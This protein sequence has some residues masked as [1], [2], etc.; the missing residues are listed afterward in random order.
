MT[1]SK[2]PTHIIGSTDSLRICGTKSQPWTIE[3]PFG[4]KLHINALSFTMTRSDHSTQ[5][6]YKY[7]VIV[8]RI[9][10]RNASICGG[11]SPREKEL[12]LSTGNTVE[13]YFDTGNKS[14]KMESGRQFIGILRI[15][16]N[17]KFISGHKSHNSRRHI[18]VSQCFFNQ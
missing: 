16:G 6:C 3:A 5:L 18:S 15:E 4:Q 13:I 8:D 14:E 1:A 11:G 7:G 17:T 10:K 9:G 2:S 12:H